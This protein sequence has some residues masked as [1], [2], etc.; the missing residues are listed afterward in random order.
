[1][2]RYDFHS[3]LGLLEESRRNYEKAYSHYVKVYRYF[4]FEEN[5]KKLVNY[6]HCHGRF[7]RRMFERMLALTSVMGKNEQWMDILRCIISPLEEKSI[8]NHDR[9]KRHFLVCDDIEEAYLKEPD[10]Y[11]F[12]KQ[13]GYIIEQCLI[14][15]SSRLPIEAISS[16]IGEHTRIF[17][18]MFVLE[19][20]R[21]TLLTYSN[22]ARIYH[23]TNDM[24][25][26]DQVASFEAIYQQ[27]I[28]G[29]PPRLHC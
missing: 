10:K 15:V 16:F 21:A 23:I 13:L 19:A 26:N 20:F 5:Y 2:G 24:V 18:R 11:V 3:C 4:F 9:N 17:S 25:L 8:K 14:N 6:T 29:F 28:K 12:I 7:V 22:N 27:R 1:V